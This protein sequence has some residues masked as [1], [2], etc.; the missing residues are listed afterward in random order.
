MRKLL[1]VFFVLSLLP[2]AVF[3]AVGATVSLLKADVLG[4]L[5]IAA[6]VCATLFS[7]NRVRTM[8]MEIEVARTLRWILVLSFAVLWVPLL[9]WAL[10][11]MMCEQILNECL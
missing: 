3:Y 2:A 7:S 11:G 5:P 10:M 4:V 1:A 8:L 6:F 9:S